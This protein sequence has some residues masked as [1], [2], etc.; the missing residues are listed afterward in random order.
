[1][2]CW[3][4]IP[5]SALIASMSH[6]GSVSSTPSIA[7]DPSVGTSSLLIH[8]R[9]VD[10]PEPLGPTMTTTSPSAISRSTFLTA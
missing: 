3:K 7:I 10:L 9:T 2:N 4:T 6:F 1:M 8:L 5:T